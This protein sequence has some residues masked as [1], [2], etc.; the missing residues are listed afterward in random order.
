M[1]RPLKGRNYDRVTSAALDHIGGRTVTKTET[2]DPGDSGLG[3][4]L[5]RPTKSMST[6]STTPPAGSVAVTLKVANCF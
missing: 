1:H 3:R 6:E 4:Y 5:P 2:G